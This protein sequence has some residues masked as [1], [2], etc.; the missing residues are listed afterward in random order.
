MLAPGPGSNNIF[1][2][3]LI[4]MSYPKYIKQALGVYLVIALIIASFIFLVY[5]LV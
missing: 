2:A 1:V 3:N 4:S 5:K